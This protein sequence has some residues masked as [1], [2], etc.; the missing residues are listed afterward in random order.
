VIVRKQRGEGSSHLVQLPIGAVLDELKGNV[1]SIGNSRKSQ[2]PNINGDAP[3]GT[4][5]L[6]VRDGKLITAGRIV[7][8][9]E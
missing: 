2:S 1:G 4:L 5:T 9:L 3:L 7:E 6:I 8:G